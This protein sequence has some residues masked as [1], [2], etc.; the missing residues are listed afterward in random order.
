MWSL[1]H[2]SLDFFADSGDAARQAGRREVRA[3]AGR[4]SLRD[5][6]TARAAGGVRESA[7]HGGYLRRRQARSARLADCIGNRHP[8]LTRPMSEPRRIYSSSPAPTARV[9]PRMRA[10]FSRPT[11]SHCPRRC[12]RGARSRG[13][14][15][16]PTP[17]GPC[18]IVRIARFGCLWFWS[19]APL[20]R[21]PH[22]RFW[23][24]PNTAPPPRSRL[25]VDIVSR[26]ICPTSGIATQTRGACRLPT[27]KTS[28]RC[29][30]NT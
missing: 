9:K 28:S 8:T 18:E 2:R 23:K 22:P 26:A 10:G 27:A 1:L 19:L 16:K 14:T 12:P 6:R 17:S 30:R 20:W 25:A 24:E 21:R 7:P 4:F 11:E 3:T 29:R 13:G 15:G 5:F